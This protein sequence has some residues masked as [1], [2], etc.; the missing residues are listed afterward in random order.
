M[1]ASDIGYVSG[2]ITEPAAPTHS[3]IGYAS[4]RIR[5]PHTPNGVKTSTGIVWVAP[6]TETS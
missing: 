3:Q 5:N 6:L 2:T 1:G 4:S